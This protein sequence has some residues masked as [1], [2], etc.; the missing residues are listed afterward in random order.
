MA[1]GQGGASHLDESQPV[2]S[3]ETIVA[4]QLDGVV[5]VEEEGGGSSSSTSG[6]LRKPG[7]RPLRT[8]APRS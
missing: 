7:V 6:S 4:T 8:S 1:Q 2:N 5:V 3:E